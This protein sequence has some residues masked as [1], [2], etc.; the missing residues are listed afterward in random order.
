[1][2]RMGGGGKACLQA[3]HN[4]N[5]DV[6]VVLSS[7]YSMDMI[8]SQLGDCTPAAILQ[9]PYSA[10]MLEQTILTLQ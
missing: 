4:I 1:M 5:P 9:K 2:P 7:G 8:S 10:E 3:L 6:C